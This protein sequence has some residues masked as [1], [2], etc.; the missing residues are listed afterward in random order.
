MTSTETIEPRPRRKWGW[1]LIAAFFIEIVVFFNI[2]YP[3]QNRIAW[4]KSYVEAQPST[5]IYMDIQIAENE[6]K[7]NKLWALEGIS[8]ALTLVVAGIGFRRRSY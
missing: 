5:A 7:L 1:F 8:L 2:I 3:V 4:D 6:A